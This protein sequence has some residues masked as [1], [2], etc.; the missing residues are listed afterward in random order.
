MEDVFNKAI[1]DLEGSKAQQPYIQTQ[2]VIN[3]LERLLS[4][5]K[6]EYRKRLLIDMMRDDEESGLYQD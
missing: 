5:Y 3:L 2:E 6:K 4:E 1:A